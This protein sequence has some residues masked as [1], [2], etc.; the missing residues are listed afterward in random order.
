MERLDLSRRIGGAAWGAR[1]QEEIL[2]QGF[3]VADTRADVVLC[4]ETGEHIPGMYEHA[5]LDNL[6]KS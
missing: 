5:V 6:A 2:P 3:D 4:L 1:R